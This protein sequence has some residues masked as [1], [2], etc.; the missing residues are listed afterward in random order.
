MA[1]TPK[2]YRTAAIF[3][4]GG[5]RFGYYLGMYQ[6]LCEHDKRPDVVLAS[7]GG[8][9]AAAFLELAHDPKR[10]LTLLK[11]PYTHQMF[12]RFYGVVPAHRGVHVLPAIKRY[13]QSKITIKKYA[14]RQHELDA[15][16]AK[17]LFTIKDEAHTP[18]WQDEKFVFEL[19]QQPPS[20]N[21]PPHSL[22]VLSRL[23]P[24]HRWQQVLR[25]S[26][27]ITTQAR[28]MLDGLPCA[29]YD[30]CP[31]RIDPDV[32]VLDLPLAVAVRASISDMYYLPPYVW[33]GQTLFGGVMDLTPVELACRLAQT[34][35][36]D[37][38]APY[39]KLLAA[40]A[41]NGVF[42]FD[43]N[44]RLRAVK[45]YH[46]V[47]WLDLADNR[48]HIKPL[49]AK[50]YHAKGYFKERHPNFDEFCAIADAQWRYGYERTSRYFNH[51]GKLWN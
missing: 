49:V 31:E 51:K 46:N 5:L 18:L 44:Q 42:G 8:A 30:D 20:A 1:D 7:C 45:K 6:A 4:G 3:A 39:D 14:L 38:K 27:G 50:H 25:P 23:H 41:I 29:L 36:I 19:S 47:H 35:F 48:Q 10:A 13:V 15:L 16:N 32:A 22:I 40:P 28:L 12:C 9:F 43:P 26:A 17:A 34:V 11:S 37:D 33:Q 21:S 24:S 2:P